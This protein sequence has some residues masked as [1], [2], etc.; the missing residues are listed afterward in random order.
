M[1]KRILVPTDGSETATLGLKEAI[2]LAQV[3]G[4]Q[5]RV[6][7]VV[8]E[9]AAA[10]PNVYGPV[11]EQLGEQLRKAGTTAL[12]TARAMVDNAGVKIETRLV[13]AFGGPAGEHIIR[14]AKDWPA[15]VIV[16][17]THGRRGVRR[18]VMGSDAEFIVRRSP[19]PILL[20]R[21]EQ[22]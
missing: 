10:L 20:V 13:E 22:T 4:G 16:C 18:I 2:R 9:L 15:D 12:A 8:D 1:Y 3:H 7:H 19:V 5:I 6:I 14:E 17:G 11:L 21:A